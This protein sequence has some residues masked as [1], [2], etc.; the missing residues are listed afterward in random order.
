MCVYFIFCFVVVV[1]IVVFFVLNYDR[2]HVLPRL[3]RNYTSVNIIG[4]KSLYVII[5]LLV[6]IISIADVKYFG[7]LYPICLLYIVF[8]NDILQ[9]TLQ[10][11]TKN[12][13]LLATA[14]ISL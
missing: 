5:F 10:A 6:S 13:K 12:C 11:V 9:R 8:N 1:V 14:R 4:I 3:N 7:Y 2:I